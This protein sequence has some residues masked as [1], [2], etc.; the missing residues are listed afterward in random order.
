MLFK[1]I[2]IKIIQLM[3]ECFLFKKA[4]SNDIL[5]CNFESVFNLLSKWYR[6]IFIFSLVCPSQTFLL[7]FSIWPFVHSPTFF[8]MYNIN[9][10]QQKYLFILAKVEV[11]PWRFPVT[12]YDTLHKKWRLS[13]K[14][15]F[16]PG[17]IL[18]K[19]SFEEAVFMKQPS[20]IL[21]LSGML[22][23]EKCLLAKKCFVLD[24]QIEILQ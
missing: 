23:S 10:L 15:S 24:L 1:I 12:P 7:F 16:T 9:D 22:L 18:T 4:K 5:I 11:S 20:F 17:F 6:S 14:T 21:N 8:S 2:F 19:N 13:Y 3:L